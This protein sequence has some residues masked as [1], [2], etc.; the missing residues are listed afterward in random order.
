MERNRIA[1]ADQLRTLAAILGIPCEV[2]D[3]PLVLS[4]QLELFRSKELVLIDTP[5]FGFREMEDASELAVF[6]ATQ[7]EMETHL[8]P[9]T[10][11]APLF[12]SDALV[13]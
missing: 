10:H 3:T 9:L 6:L 5:G 12:R 7:P 4:H 2:T 13:C 11:R 8:V 1:A